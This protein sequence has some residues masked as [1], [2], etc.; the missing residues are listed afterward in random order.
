MAVRD[1]D[2]G[3]PRSQTMD[4]ASQSN[5]EDSGPEIHDPLAG[6]NEIDK[7]GLKG[8]SLMMSNFPDYAAMVAGDN[9]AA[10]GLDLNSTE[11]VLR[12]TCLESR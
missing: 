1:Q 8:F 2:S 4:S 11:F 6:M 3:I 9:V 12:F 5:A 7:W 10:Y